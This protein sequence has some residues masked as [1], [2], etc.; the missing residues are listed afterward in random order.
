MAIVT[1]SVY[2]ATFIVVFWLPG[3]AALEAL[4]PGKYEDARLGLAAALGVALVCYL[5]LT[6]TGF[7]GLIIPLFLSAPLVLAISLAVFLAS[8]LLVRHRQGSLKGAF[9][10]LATQVKGAFHPRLAL[11]LTVVLLLYLVAYDSA[12]FDQER[13]ISRACLLPLHAYLQPHAPLYFDGCLECFDGRNAFLEWNGHQR[14]GPSALVA[15]FVSLFGF[16]G[17]RLLHAVLGMLAAWFGFHTAREKL[18]HPGYGYLAGGLMALNPW[19]L[20]ISL[21]DENI[22]ALALGSVLL[23][24]LLARRT[25]WLLVG[26]FFGLFVGIRHIGLLSLPALFYAIWVGRRTTHYG[27][28]WYHRLFGSEPWANVTTLVLGI[29][30]FSLP[31]LFVHG[32][33]WATGELSYES[34]AGLPPTPH[35]FLGFQF[36]LQGLLNWPFVARMLRSPYNGFPNLI[37]LPTQVIA[38]VGL[39]GIAALLLGL[40]HTVKR[41]RAGL[42]LGLLWTGPQWL[43]LAL[44]A[45]WIEPNKAGIFLCFIQPVI[46]GL[47]AGVKSAVGDYRNNTFAPAALTVAAVVLVGG[48]LLLALPGFKTPMDARNLQARPGYAETLFPVTPPMM[49]ASELDYA[50]ADRNRLA[51]PHVLPDYRGLAL[52]GSPRL[53]ASRFKQLWRDFGRPELARYCPRPKDFLHLLSGI[54]HPETGATVPLAAMMHRPISRFQGQALMPPPCFEPASDGELVGLE[55]SLQAPPLGGR[56]LSLSSQSATTLPGTG[57][58]VLFATLGPQSWSAGEAVHVAAVPGGPG[59]IWLFVWY[60]NY[61]FDHLVGN[62]LI[63][64]FQVASTPAVHFSCPAGS[65]IRLVDVSSV[66]PNRF[67]VTYVPADAPDRALGPYPSSY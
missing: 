36:S 20:S 27:A 42:V 15:P 53:L 6:V 60:G 19:A 65:L 49:L 33:G 51:Q 63:E 61:R 4:A 30:V 52:V 39:V 26:L 62:D 14:M 48:G 41:A 59:E 23:Y 12:A 16:P 34:F 3:L 13:C 7:L 10:T 11:F 37:A 9:A 38:T 29:L 66:V 25:Q 1:A 56:G 54:P 57:R 24:L 67:H 47:V 35:H 5:T 18:G 46:L 8:L 43:L 64:P 28:S 32:R 31:W 21:V 22:M 44:A 40:W 17:F 55:Y 50:G 45:N 2:I 58:S